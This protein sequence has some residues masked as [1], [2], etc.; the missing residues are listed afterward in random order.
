MDKP[1]YCRTTFPCKAGLWGR[2]GALSQYDYILR[3]TPSAAGPFW[4][5]GLP[6]G[7][8]GVSISTFWGTHFGTSSASWG[9]RFGTSGPPWRTMGAG[10]W[11][12]DFIWFYM[13]LGWLRDLWRLAFWVQKPEN[14]LFFQ[15]CFQIIF[16]SIS[17]S[18]FQ[19]LGLSNQGFRM[20]AIT[21]L[22]FSRKS[23]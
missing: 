6:F 15:A 7:M 19:R 20:E 10:G 8:L 4:L 21:K 9:D 2:A 18:K 22:E 5:L 13:I 23:F 14:V 11:T 17:E 1:T 12:R 16:L 3:A